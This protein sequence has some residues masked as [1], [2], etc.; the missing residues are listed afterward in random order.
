M[1]LDINVRNVTQ[2]RRKLNIDL[3]IE[4]FSEC[5]RFTHLAHLLYYDLIILTTDCYIYP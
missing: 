3:K 1:K 4:W 5:T 2:E